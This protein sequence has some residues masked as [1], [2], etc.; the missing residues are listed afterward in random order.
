[1]FSGDSHSL[2]GRRH[3][4]NRTPQELRSL[5]ALERRLVATNAYRTTIFVVQIIAVGIVA[6]EGSLGV[7]V[8]PVDRR[9]GSPRAVAIIAKA[10]IVDVV[11]ISLKLVWCVNNI[12][13]NLVTCL[14]ASIGDTRAEVHRNRDGQLLRLWRVDLCDGDRLG[15]AHHHKCQST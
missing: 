6:V 9:V 14:V 3:V 10:H 11:A 2:L 4:L 13:A 5:V 1:M 15:A 7:L 8:G 12:E